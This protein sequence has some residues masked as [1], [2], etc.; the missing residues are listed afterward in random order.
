MKDAVGVAVENAVIEL[1]AAAMRAGVLDQHVVI[2]MLAAVADEEAVDETL[3]AFAGQ[4]GM[5]IVAN[6]PAAQKH[7]MRAHIGAARLLSTQSRDVVRLPVFALEQVMG[8]DRALTSDEFGDRVRKGNAAPERNVVFH[9]AGFSGIFSHN[10]ITGIGH[11]RMLRRNGDEQE[12]DRRFQDSAARQMHV[13]AIFDEG[14]IQRGESI[15]FDIE[16]MA[17]VRLQR[18]AIFSSDPTSAPR[19][20]LRQASNPHTFRQGSQLRQVG[21]KS[22]VDENELAGR[23]GNAAGVQSVAINGAGL[24]RVAGEL[25]RRL[26]DG[27]DV[28]EAPVFIL[29]CGEAN[30]AK[31]GEAAL[32]QGAQPRRLARR[33]GA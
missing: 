31:A 12:I 33:I 16:V 2:H 28:R 17:Q 14:R 26:R 5:D 11:L 23:A 27:I 10:Q 20:P 24:A 32:A 18:C 4:H 7:R 8:N 19:D 22:A 30:F 13:G 3:A 15:A 25:K 21:S 1:A 9:D 6:E 29:S